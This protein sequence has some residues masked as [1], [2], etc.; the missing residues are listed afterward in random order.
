M[1]KRF[2]Q[3]IKLLQQDQHSKPQDKLL[4]LS[5]NRLL[6]I[7]DLDSSSSQVAVYEK[8]NVRF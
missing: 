2:I 3:C 5:S 7:R 6:Y 4:D 1:Q 8:I